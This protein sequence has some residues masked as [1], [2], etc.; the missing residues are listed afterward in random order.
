MK[1]FSVPTYDMAPDASKPVIDRF[2]KTM[3][4]IPN[5]YAG[6]VPLDVINATKIASIGFI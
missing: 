1:P 6:R 2:N 5:M 4:K 3:G